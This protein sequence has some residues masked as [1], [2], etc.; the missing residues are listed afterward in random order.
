MSIQVQ[1]YEKTDIEAC[2]LLLFERTVFLEQINIV[3]RTVYV[4]C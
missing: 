4:L 3:R 1:V 2:Y